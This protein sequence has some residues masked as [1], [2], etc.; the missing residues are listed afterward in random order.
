MTTLE[1]LVQC[2]KLDG[3]YCRLKSLILMMRFLSFRTKALNDGSTDIAVLLT[4]GIVK[5]IAT[6]GSSKI[7]GIYVQSPLCWGIH[8]GAQQEDITDV[9]SLKGKVWAVSRMTSGSHLMAG[10]IILRK[11]SLWVPC[12]PSHSH[13]NYS[14]LSQLSSP[15]RKGGILPHLSIRYDLSPCS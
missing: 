4:E 15:S 9:A 10:Q 3:A 6:G 11:A 2:M 1:A 8:T 14:L 7:V 13:V 12:Y 5:D